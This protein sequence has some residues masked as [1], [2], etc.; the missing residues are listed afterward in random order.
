MSEFH[1][2][3]LDGG[4]P[5]GYLAALG[6]LRATSLAYPDTLVQMRW[7]NTGG[8]RPW[9]IVDKIVDE[10][11]WITDLHHFLHTGV[12]QPAFHI[13]ND[14]VMS[15]QAFQAVAAKAQKAAS[16]TDRQ[17]A[18]FVAAFGSEVVESV[19]N[20]KKT[21]N[22]ADT[23]FRTMSG[24]GHQ[25]FLGF[26]KDIA[27]ATEK[28][29][30]TQAVMDNWKYTD[31][32]PNMRWAPLD[33]RRYAQ[34]WSNPSDDQPKSVRGANRL[35]IEAL[36]LF[37]TAPVGTRLETTGFSQ[38]HGQSA[39]WTWPIWSDPID[40]NVV[41]SLLALEMLQHPEID[42]RYLKYLQGM[43]IVE[44]FRSQRMT[45][46]KYRNFSIAVPA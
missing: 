17:F 3:G 34:R 12:D 33:D 42:R 1:L 10:T 37:P 21:G 45:I 24:A 36:P 30:I 25:H 20:G 7:V 4:N 38:R 11:Q 13:A 32:G 40:Q 19:V 18:D 14:L 39:V 29:H 23:A 44:V 6:T 9:L 2:L 16:T 5:L 27:H 8:W 41:R 43:G 28:H 35:A 26:M 22:I 46:G 31:S 15:C